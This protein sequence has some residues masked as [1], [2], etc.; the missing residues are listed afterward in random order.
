MSILKPDA[1]RPSPHPGRW[2]AYSL[3]P[4]CHPAVRLNAPDVELTDN[5][6]L[7]VP[8]DFKNMDD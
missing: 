4:G 1:I 8:D 6:H 2:E 5:Q 3:W 7:D